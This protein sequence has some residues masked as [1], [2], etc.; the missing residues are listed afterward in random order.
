MAVISIVLLVI[1]Y[2]SLSGLLNSI[3][4]CCMILCASI[5]CI[6]AIGG[7]IK[8]GSSVLLNIAYPL[9]IIKLLSMF[10]AIGRF[11]WIACYI[12]FLSS[13]FIVYKYSNK[14]IANIIITV[15]LVIQIV[16]LY[17]SM[18]TKFEY[19]EENK[20]SYSEKEWEIA[21]KDV[22]HIITYANNQT[23]ELLKMAY[24][25]NKNNCT[26]SDFYF[27][28]DIENVGK[29]KLEYLDKLIN[30]EIDEGYIYVI[31]EEDAKYLTKITLNMYKIDE[32][33]VITDKDIEEL[34]KLV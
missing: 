20:I 17:P 7:T 28:R 1:N 12:I 22:S 33:V 26:V 25:A 19:S 34:T 24:I 11:I 18:I 5:S 15:C 3:N 2:K 10:R 30:N 32:F 14:K 23:S 6:L 29:M 8:V 31:N 13:I 9:S 27:A 16:D 21:L 4:V